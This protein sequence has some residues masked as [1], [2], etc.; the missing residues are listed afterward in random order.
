M[1]S[2]NTG[3]TAFE[4][5]GGRVDRCTPNY[6]TPTEAQANNIGSDIAKSGNRPASKRMSDDIK[7]MENE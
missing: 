2:K 3:E 5:I 7:E 4:Q 6:S 1:A